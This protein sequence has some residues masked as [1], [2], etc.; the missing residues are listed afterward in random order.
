[1]RATLALFLL[2]AFASSGC[3]TYSDK[4]VK[5]TE[6]TT[7]GDFD[8]SI[9]RVEKLMGVDKRGELP[10][11]F[12]SETALG[13]L[14][15]GILEQAV[16]D[17]PGSSRD[18]IVADRELQVLDLTSDTAGS[19][20]QYVYSDSAT[21]YE[22]TPTEKLSLNSFNMM[23]FL[24]MGDLSG[25]RVEARRYT[26][27]QE[28][29]RTTNIKGVNV[30]IGEYLA[31]FTFE[32]LGEWQGAM[33]YYEEALQSHDFPSLHGPVR[34]LAPM[35]SYRGPNIERI[36][37]TAP[38][39]PNRA[40][41]PEDAQLGDLLVVVSIGRVPHKVPERMPIGMAVGVAGSWITG[42]PEVL[43]Y[44]AMKFVV[45]PELVQGGSVYGKVSLRVDD[46]PAALELSSNLGNEITK[47][48]EFIK[49]RII[50]AAISRMIARAAVSEGL[51]Q[52][53]NQQSEGLGWAVALLTEGLMVAMDKPDT[54]SWMLLPDQV[55]VY[56]QRVP[57]G[58]KRVE[59]SLGSDS[60]YSVIKDVTLR[61]GGY[62]AVVVTSPR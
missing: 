40:A 24:A 60:A 34:R 35:T 13:L 55:Y 11:D 25:S 29:L 48:Y 42:N 7:A 23:N 33:R 4:M 30:A 50:G 52:A 2:A 16:F 32:M 21:R 43:G 26:V 61:P 45:Y 56:R 8:G 59:V 17:F 47:E 28:Y 15:R 38:V 57:A 20:G 3:A 58:E 41:R 54:R 46:K 49:P 18:F 1:V 37:D 51:R 36:L 12:E 19:I 5:V 31:G 53:G 27:M 39:D 62:A 44:S 6:A 22:S 9:A 14:E 10:D